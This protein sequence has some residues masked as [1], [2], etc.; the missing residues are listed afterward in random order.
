MTEKYN[1]RSICDL[2]EKVLDIPK[3]KLKDKSRKRP[4]QIARQV[5]AMI[6][7]NEENIH[8]KIIGSILNRDRSLIFYYQHKHEGNYKYCSLYR[9]AYNKVYKAYKDI[10]GSKDIFI[11]GSDIKS[12]LLKNDIT[13]APIGKDDIIICVK[14]GESSTLIKSTYLDFVNQL[15]NIKL[16]LKNYHYKIEII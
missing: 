16:A 9:D 3:G 11:K 7:R 14:S 15:E 8:Q 2:T 12:Y 6:G 1:F 4:L 10:E 13:E 5:A